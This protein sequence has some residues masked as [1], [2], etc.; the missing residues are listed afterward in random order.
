MYNILLLIGFPGL[1]VFINFFSFVFKRKMLLGN[2]LMILAEL[3]SLFILPFM[4]AGFG[5]ENRCCADEVDTPAFSPEHQLSIAVIILLSLGSYLYSRFRTR[6]ATPVVEAFINISLLIGIILGF[7]LFFH[8][9]EIFFAIFGSLPVVLLGILM[10]IKNQLLFIEQSA[11]NNKT[12]HSRLQALA[13]KLLTAEPLV[14]FPILLV[15][16][17]PVLVLIAA[18]LLLFGQKPDA[19][20][21]AFTDTYRHGLSQWDYKCDNVNCGGHYLCSVAANGHG[22]IVKPQ[23]LGIRNNNPIICNRQLLI[24]NAFEDLVQERMPFIH[25]MIRKQYNKVGDLIHRHYHLFSIKLVSDCIYIL[26]KPLEWFFL[27]TLYTFDRKPEN[28]IEMQYL[29]QADRAQIEV[30]A[31]Q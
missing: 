21:R 19:M 6:I 28:R 1:V 13:W 5:K 26:M 8:A 22:A 31:I 25:R 29:L 24:S 2:G 30:Q 12:S 17:L 11:E 16:C 15:C 20:I 7:F 4:Y 27:L 18:A 14:K 23:R 9:N 3:G 10:L